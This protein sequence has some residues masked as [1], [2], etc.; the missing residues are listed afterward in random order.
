LLI[1]PTSVHFCIHT[2]EGELV[3][4]FPTVVLKLG[5]DTRWKECQLT[6]MILR[7]EEEVKPEGE[8][9]LVEETKVMPKAVLNLAQEQQ[10]VII[11]V[12]KF[13][14]DLNADL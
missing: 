5:S 10:Y 12:K 7:S 3:L 9:N 14:R 13:I 4:I 2:K 8:L 6:Q 11:V 1:A